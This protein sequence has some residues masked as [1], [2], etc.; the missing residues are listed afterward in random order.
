MNP[1]CF[2]CLS[3]QTITVLR[4]ITLKQFRLLNH[5]NR[6]FLELDSGQNILFQNTAASYNRFKDCVY[7]VPQIL[8]IFVSK[9][10][11]NKQNN[12][13]CFK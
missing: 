9:C 2:S 5:C 6:I 10:L 4:N 13:I 7:K 1:I 8:D 11:N 3:K 12:E